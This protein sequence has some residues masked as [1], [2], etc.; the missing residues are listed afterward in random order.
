MQL[1]CNITPLLQKC[2]RSR[3]LTLVELVVVLA[4]LVALSGLI[5]PLVSGMLGQTNSATNATLV[6]DVNRA[7]GTHWARHEKYP[8][9][10]DSLVTVGGSL[11]GS[12]S[13]TLLGTTTPGATAI[14]Q[15]AALTERQAISL[16]TAG[17]TTVYSASGSA[18]NVNFAFDGPTTITTGAQVAMLVTT[19]TH[20]NFASGV[21][22]LQQLDSVSQGAS[23]VVFGLGPSTSLRGTTVVDVP[24]VNSGNPRN[25]YARMMCVFL[26][27]ASG[28]DEASWRAR[29][30]GSFLPDGSSLRDNLNDYNNAKTQP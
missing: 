6:G 23:Y 29:F 15:T 9:N 13:T 5:T 16:S 18:A 27:P 28:T 3:G 26:L 30:V 11:Y 1:N 10:W 4:I 12:L 22:N 7:V 24:L 2:R 25:D 17:I 14:L 8:S 21:V 20:V 19:G